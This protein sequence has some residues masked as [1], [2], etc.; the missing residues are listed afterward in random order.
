[1]SRQLRTVMIGAGNRANQVIYPAFSSLAQVDIA[2]ICDL[3][4]DRLRQTAD[5]Y[6]IRHRY[7]GGKLTAYQ[8]MIKELQ[9]DAVV[10]IGQP[11]QMYDIWLW[12]LQQG[13]N[14]YIE[15]PLA[16][17]IHQAR[18]LTE[19][20]R[21]NNCVTQVSFQRRYTPMV[22]E[23]RDECLRRGNIV[24]ALCRFYKYD[25]AD[26]FDARDHMFDDTVHSI[27]TLRWICGS[28]IVSVESDVKRIQTQDINFI[29]ATLYFANGAN[30]YLLNSWSS[31]KRIFS[32]EMH[33]PGIFAEAEHEGKG[34]LYA[35][36][37]VQGIEYD[38]RAVAG[39]NDFYVYTGVQAAAADFVRACL[40]G[41]QPACH[42]ADA[43]K[44]IET[45]EIILAQALL[46]SQSKTSG[47]AEV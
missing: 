24:H 32:V 22:R 4:S 28:D 36:G 12:C 29:A 18:S 37:D 34:Y 19:A 3:D 23:L 6:Q 10:A 16:L 44:T 39:S 43:L 17:T 30:G 46:T 5:R 25:I 9:P 38:T 15:K 21:R 2:G 7:S 8:D 13:L 40:Q 31:G 1:M 33:A 35:D 26:R 20:A 42:F 11:H 45:A 14:L 41:G 27:D 47:I